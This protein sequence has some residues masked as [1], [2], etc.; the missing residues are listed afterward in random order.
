M[1]NISASLEDSKKQYTPGRQASI[2]TTFFRSR[3]SSTR[4]SR[5]PPKRRTS[6]FGC[7]RLF[8]CWVGV[9]PQ[10]ILTTSSCPLL[11]VSKSEIQPRHN[12]RPGLTSFRTNF[13][14]AIMSAV[15]PLYSSLSGW[16][17]PVLVAISPPLRTHLRMAD[18][19]VFG[20][21]QLSAG[22]DVSPCHLRC[23]G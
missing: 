16:C 22:F 21:T 6:V 18:P 10:S 19:E 11:A 9:S 7:A 3:R 8:L 5:H 14:A 15:W 2:A 17:L 4:L 12:L 20:P 13:P 23:C 1:Y